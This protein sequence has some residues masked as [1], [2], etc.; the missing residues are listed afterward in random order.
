[1][2][3][4]ILTDTDEYEWRIDDGILWYVTNGQ[5]VEH[6]VG[7]VGEVTQEAAEGLV[8]AHT[9]IKS[10][11]CKAKMKVGDDIEVRG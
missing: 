4:T 3:G 8:I 5:P 6:V 9:G 7:M 1:M 10:K 11:S 2:R